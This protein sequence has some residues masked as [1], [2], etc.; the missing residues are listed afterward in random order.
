MFFKKLNNVSLQTSLTSRKRTKKNKTE[1][2]LRPNRYAYYQYKL[3][4]KKQKRFL[5]KKTFY[6]L[7]NR[8]TKRIL[9]FNQNIK[10]TFL[11]TKLKQQKRKRIFLTLN[12]LNKQKLL[13]FYFLQ[14]RRLL[15]SLQL[16]R[17]Y[18]K[19]FSLR[20]LSSSI[21]RIHLT[22]V[23]KNMI[24][25]LRQILKKNLIRFRKIKGFFDFT[26]IFVFYII[27]KAGFCLRQWLKYFFERLKPRD[28]NTSQKKIFYLF[29]TAFKNLQTAAGTFNH[30]RIEIKGKIDGSLRTR[31]MEFGLS[32]PRQSVI[33]SPQYNQFDI[34]SY[35]GTLGFRFWF[36]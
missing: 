25:I 22:Y 23:K 32:V 18:K 29:D 33:F 13:N 15:S 31:K 28:H 30:Y 10:S 34:K 17:F 4:K 19:A 2:D 12:V 16:K 35:T 14:K 21:P 20:V 27:F 24:I 9:Q 6:R 5:K 36:Y 7:K 3:K 26:Y 11:Y 8:F 1:I